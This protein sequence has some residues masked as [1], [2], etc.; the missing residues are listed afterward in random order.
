MVAA[1]GQEGG[2]VFSGLSAH[3]P[4]LAGAIAAAA[5]EGPSWEP[6]PETPE[7]SL[8]ELRSLLETWKREVSPRTDGRALDPEKARILQERGYWGP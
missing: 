1:V 8:P 3:E 6:W 2:L 4:R 5:P 7:E